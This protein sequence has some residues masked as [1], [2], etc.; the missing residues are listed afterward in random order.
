VGFLGF[1]VLSRLLILHHRDNP[2][3]AACHRPVGALWA[4]ALSVH[5]LLHGFGIGSV[6]PARRWLLGTPGPGG[7]SAARRDR[8]L[9]M[10]AYGL[11]LAAHAG[12]FLA[13]GVGS[14]PRPTASRRSPG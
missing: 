13:I 2:A 4:L 8:S 5:S 10:H 1:L 3:C 11:G 14:S 12:I 6:R 7:G 9:L